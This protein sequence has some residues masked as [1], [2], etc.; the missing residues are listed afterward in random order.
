MD[1]LVAEK[2]V[3]YGPCLEFDSTSPRHLNLVPLMRQIR[4]GNPVLVPYL[5]R[6]CAVTFRV[7]GV[8]RCD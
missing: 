3:G 6:T 2:T 7:A 5:C 8:D 1:F 4:R